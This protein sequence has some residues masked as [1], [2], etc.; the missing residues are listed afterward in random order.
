MLQTIKKIGKRFTRRQIIIFCLEIIICLLLLSLEYCS[1]ETSLPPEVATSKTS[2]I[3]PSGKFLLSVIDLSG[4]MYFQ[5]QDRSKQKIV[6][7]CPKKFLDNFTNFFLWDKQDRVWVYSGDIGIFFWEQNR[8]TQK[9]EKYD[10][11]ESSAVA[12]LFLKNV[13]PKYFNLPP[14]V[15][16]ADKPA[17]SSSGKYVLAIISVWEKKTRWLSF[18]ILNQKQEVLYHSS[19]R[20]AAY[21][22]T[23]FLWDENNRVWVHSTKNEKETEIEPESKKFTNLQIY[24]WEQKNNKEWVKNLYF[25][26][27]I[28]KPNFLINR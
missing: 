10:Y 26:N 20:I 12:P 21:Q 15:A 18:Q 19:E 13:R 3:S 23:Y 16:T 5:I 22:P 14:E 25:A 1:E 6:Y 2:A 24:F 11:T 9:W 27:K 8:D 28:P 17:I 4:E 7:S